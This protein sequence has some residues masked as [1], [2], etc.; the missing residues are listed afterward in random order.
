MQRRQ[1]KRVNKLV[2]DTLVPLGK[3]C[4]K[5]VPGF[6]LDFCVVHGL[7]IADS[8]VVASINVTICKSFPSGI[9]TSVSLMIGI[10]GALVSHERIRHRA[11]Q[12]T[13]RRGTNVAG[14]GIHLDTFHLGLWSIIVYQG[15][16]AREKCWHP[17]SNRLKL[18]RHYN[19]FPS[20]IQP[21]FVASSGTNKMIIAKNQAKSREKF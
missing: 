21:E 7:I 9:I 1:G 20:F 12:E 11:N 19:T 18:E 14:L 2:L 13:R 8:L 3:V 5:F 15:K 16:R 6:E 10:F 4:T 17:E